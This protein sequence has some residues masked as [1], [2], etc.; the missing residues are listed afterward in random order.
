MIYL[1]EIDEFTYDDWYDLYINKKMLQ[2]EIAEFLGTTKGRVNKYLVMH[3]LN[4]EAKQNSYKENN[5]QRD[6]IIG[7]LLGDG[8]LLQAQ[9]S[10]NYLLKLSHN[11][12]QLAYLQLKYD[13]LKSLMVPNKKIRKYINPK[14]PDRKPMYDFTTK[15][16]P[17]FHKYKEMNIYNLLTS[18]NATSLLVWYLDDGSLHSNRYASITCASFNMREC[19]YAQEILFHKFGI[20]SSI[21]HSKREKNGLQGLSI[22]REATKKMNEVFRNSEIYTLMAEAVPYK[23]SIND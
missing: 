21:T 12:D 11:E 14:Y 16:L 13:F 4:G 22:P 3:G 23:L 15:S 19:E 5:I 1:K 18:L 2:R 7:S 20:R 17:I 9:R 6:I 8:A 10:K